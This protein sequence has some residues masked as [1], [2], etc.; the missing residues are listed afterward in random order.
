MRRNGRFAQKYTDSYTHFM[1]T[2]ISIPNPI[3][4][5]TEEMA[6][7]LGMSRSEFFTT[8]VSDYMRTH[9]YYNITKTLNQVYSQTKAAVDEELASMQLC[10]IPRDTKQINTLNEGTKLVLGM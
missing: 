3:F 8:A 6:H 9:R 5:A 4:E 1:K 10:S 2:A 7:R